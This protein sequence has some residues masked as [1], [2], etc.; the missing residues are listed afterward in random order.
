VGLYTDRVL[1]L[2]MMMVV[3]AWIVAVAVRVVRSV[4]AA[5]VRV[6]RVAVWIVGRIVTGVAWIVVSWIVVS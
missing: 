6:V 5:V 4:L 2:P 1:G 3:I